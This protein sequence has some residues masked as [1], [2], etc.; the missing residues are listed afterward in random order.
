MEKV[1]DAISKEALLQELNAERFVRK[2]NNGN[3]EIYIITYHD[4]PNLMREIGRLREVTFRAA[5][6]GSCSDTK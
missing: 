6:G 4:S 2:T 5:G 1:I 3:N